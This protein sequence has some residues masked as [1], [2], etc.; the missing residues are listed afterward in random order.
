MIDYPNKLNIIFDKLD[1]FNI[2]PIIIGGYIRDKLLNLDSKD[3]DIELYGINSLSKLETILEE[4]GN[5]NSVG[6]SFGV[7]K[8]KF[9]ELDI[10]FSLPRTD[11]KV[12]DGHRGFS[13]K[14]DSLLDFKMAT[15][16]RDFTVNAIG[17]D[18]KEKKL[19]DPFNGRVDLKNGVLKAVDILKF[20]ED[21][22][23]VLRAIQFTA[24][25]EFA[26]KQELYLK[27]KEM[28]QKNILN[29]LPKDR[30]FI[31]L[32]KLLL[33]SKRP[34]LG[35]SLLKELDGFTYFKELSYLTTDEFNELL[36]RVDYLAKQ[37]IENK[38]R[39][40]ALFLTL[41]SSDLSQENSLAFLN[42]LTD[43]KELISEVIAIQY[44]KNSI[45]LESIGDYD[46]F[47]L[48]MSVKL[49]SFMQFMQAYTL[50]KDMP[51]I[52]TLRDRAKE[53]SIFNHKAEAILQGRDLISLGL[54]PSPEF[55]KLLA[56]AYEAQINSQ[57]INHNEAIEW[58]KK[59]VNLS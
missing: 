4:F 52:E 54:K 56:E 35:L 57:Y 50:G 53:L 24:R 45:N 12:S 29:E 9:K 39:K 14:T 36:K 13:I 51:T 6:K 32:Q 41:M 38:N 23:R 2:K 34:S 10:D 7:C 17:Y 25:F 19:L 44:C 33:K 55:S 1:K 22:L 40:L 8:L 18:V 43:K 16:R 31:E 21:P 26:L 49:E 15:S 47:K 30:I 48:A 20:D 58:L 3:I 37:K 11:S 42:S 5:V 27:C 46:L 28:L 59:R